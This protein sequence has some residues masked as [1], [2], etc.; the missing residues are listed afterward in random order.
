MPQDAQHLR[1]LWMCKRSAFQ[2]H[3]PGSHAMLH[4]E[5]C[6]PDQ[7]MNRTA[8]RTIDISRLSQ[9]TGVN[10]STLR[11]WESRYGI[12]RPGRSTTG[13]R[14]YTVEDVERLLVIKDLLARGSRLPELK[15]LSLGELKALHA[16]APAAD[17]FSYDAIL[18]LERAVDERDIDRFATL[19]RIAFS[20]MPAAVAVD[21]FS[22]ALR[23]VG[24]RWVEGVI[25]IGDEHRLSARARDVIQ[26]ATLAL[27][28][29]ARRPA[30][31]FA[32]LSGENHELGLMAGAYTAASLGH[33]V[34]Y[35]GAD[36]PPLDL[37]RNVQE[38]GAA[39]LVLSVVHAHSRAELQQRLDELDRHLPA[40]IAVWI[41]AH[42]ATLADVVLPERFVAM[43]GYPDLR[44]RLKLAFDA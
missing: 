33:A 12:I 29:A 27:A 1:R 6:G 41:G 9:L 16:E 30:I 44:R 22:H 21:I 23:H 11:S 31:A 2:Y 17:P 36:M 7:V 20:S 40:T 13:H 25:G 4:G 28:P 42:A 3:F 24:R 14:L 37:A 39:A 18:H 8:D 5:N 32:T 34:I 38:V 10:V 43:N 35:Y 19:M 15:D 26:S